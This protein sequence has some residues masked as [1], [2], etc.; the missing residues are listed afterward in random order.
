MLYVYAYT[1][2]RNYIGYEKNVSI[3]SNWKADGDG[4]AGDG[5]VKFKLDDY[6]KPQFLIKDES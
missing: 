5:I 4:Q 2:S 6:M 3:K 1:S